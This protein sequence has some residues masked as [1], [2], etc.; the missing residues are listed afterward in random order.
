MQ[1]CYLWRPQGTKQARGRHEWRP[2]GALPLVFMQDRTETH[3]PNHYIMVFP[4]CL[5]LSAFFWYLFNPILPPTRFAGH[6][7]L[8][9]RL[10]VR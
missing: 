5:L 7:P 10:L 8:R 6:L 4:K 9:G 1:G 2:Y 3:F